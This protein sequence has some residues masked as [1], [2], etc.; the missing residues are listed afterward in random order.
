MAFTSPVKATFSS[1]WASNT[2]IKLSRLGYLRRARAILESAAIRG[3]NR[4][5]VWK[6]YPVSGETGNHC[7]KRLAN[8]YQVM[9]LILHEPSNK[10]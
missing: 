1:T 10:R 9:R 8:Y 3:Q 6:D 2:P 4:G 5:C 7:H